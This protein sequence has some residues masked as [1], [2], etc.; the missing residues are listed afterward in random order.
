M[1][2]FWLKDAIAPAVDP[3]SISSL[4]APLTRI[5]SSASSL[6]PEKAR[7][8]LGVLI[9][10]PYRSFSMSRLCQ[11][12]RCSGCEIRR[13]AFSRQRSKYFC[14]L[15]WVGIPILTIASGTISSCGLLKLWK[16]QR[17]PPFR[18]SSKGRRSLHFP[19]SPLSRVIRS[20]ISLIKLISSLSR[21]FLT[22]LLT[23][24][25]KNVNNP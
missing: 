10:P 21:N 15:P 12:L 9:A 22:K 8:K 17:Y 2:S 25:L 24:Y 1:S 16:T 7:M 20:E 6:S 5:A 18:W 13:R 3:A 14:S 23:L 19:I 11:L 4:T